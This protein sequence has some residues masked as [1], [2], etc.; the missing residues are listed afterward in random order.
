MSEGAAD[1]LGLASEAGG[2]KPRLRPGGMNQQQLGIAREREADA[3]V[4]QLVG[5]GAGV[6]RDDDP[7]CE[8]DAARWTG[9]RS[10]ATW[11]ACA[12]PC[13]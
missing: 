6:A 3:E 1:A 5:V 4:E 11:A 9:A 7:L 2:L 13:S 12:R 10:A 8:G